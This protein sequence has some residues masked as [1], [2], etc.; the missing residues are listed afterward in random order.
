[1]YAMGS[2]AIAL[3]FLK[4]LD[5]IDCSMQFLKRLYF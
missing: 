2:D 5:S 3:I 4:E 1:M